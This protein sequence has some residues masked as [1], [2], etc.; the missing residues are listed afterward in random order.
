MRTR[1]TGVREVRYGAASSTFGTISAL[2]NNV[3]ADT[4]LVP[5]LYT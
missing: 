1:V 5:D 3:F 4:A 2:A